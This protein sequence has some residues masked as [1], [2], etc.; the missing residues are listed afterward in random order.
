MQIPWG[1]VGVDQENGTMICVVTS[2]LLRRQTWFSVRKIKSDNEI[3]NAMEYWHSSFLKAVL[4]WRRSISASASTGWIYRLS[5]SWVCIR[6]PNLVAK[7]IWNSLH[8]LC[9]KSSW[10]HYDEKIYQP[11]SWIF[12]QLAQCKQVEKWLISPRITRFT[13]K[14]VYCRSFD[15]QSK[16]KQQNLSDWGYG[17]DRYETANISTRIWLPFE[18]LRK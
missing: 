11:L 4:T 3:T 9:V 8:S 7:R 15:I 14:R 10:I 5:Q 12:F 17:W 13:A 6:R 1:K 2:K 18:I 16:S